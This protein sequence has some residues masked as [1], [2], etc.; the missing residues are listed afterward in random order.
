MAKKTSKKQSSQQKPKITIYY[1]DRLNY[2]E[3]A[4]TVRELLVTALADTSIAAQE[5]DID[6]EEMAKYLE[7]GFR[8]DA[9]QDLLGTTLGKGVLIGSYLE[10]KLNLSRIEEAEALE[11][12]EESG[13]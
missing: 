2:Q 13:Q 9:L 12:L 8:P 11:E 3:I 1:A 5:G 4:Y 6:I 10:Y 7:Q